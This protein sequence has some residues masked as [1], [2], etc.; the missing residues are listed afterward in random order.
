MFIIFFHFTFLTDSL[1]IPPADPQNI[2]IL[3]SE[4]GRIQS[5]LMVLSIEIRQL[6]LA[7][8]CPLLDFGV[9]KEVWEKELEPSFRPEVY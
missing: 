7:L 4:R 1:W 2:K 3:A 6:G 9:G 5:I 8:D